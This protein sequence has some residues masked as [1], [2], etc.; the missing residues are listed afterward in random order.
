MAQGKTKLKGK[1]LANG[2]HNKNKT[3]KKNSGFQK[4]KSE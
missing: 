4:R 1:L 2:K 3:N